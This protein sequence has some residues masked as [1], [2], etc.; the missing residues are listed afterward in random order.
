[1]AEF[2]RRYV[3]YPLEGA[4]AWLFFG[5]F[6]LLPAPVASDV[7]G[8]VGRT[9]GSVLPVNR[10]AIRN[11]DLAMPGT[12]DAEK[13]RIIRGMWDNLGRVFAE[14]PHIERFTGKKGPSR[15]EVIGVENAECISDEAG[16][17]I[18]F[19]LHLSSW[20][21]PALSMEVAGVPYVQ[22]YR[23]ANNPIV[24]RMIIRAR[25]LPQDRIM[26][27]GTAAARKSLEVLK[28]GGRIGMAVDQK[29][30]AGMSVPFFD[31][32]AMTPTA[33]A[34][35]ALRFERPAIPIVLVRV[36][37][38][39]FRLTIYPAIESPRTDDR[40]ADIREMMIRI[41]QFLE[42]R[43]REHPEQWLWLHRRWPEPATPTPSVSASGPPATEGRAVPGT[44]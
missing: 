42:E 28:R 25:R 11:I 21:I 41:N 34:Q 5:F 29:L 44:D 33:V 32:E 16:G 15:V 39:R 19:S 37:G 36:D 1:M 10:R 2:V 4:L 23:P 9:I 35:L 30:N 38:S 8:W 43:I 26:P 3:R 13:A 12:S 24:D 14:Y 7:G 40:H 6:R 18:I 17:G 31:H 22:V 20:E 27:K